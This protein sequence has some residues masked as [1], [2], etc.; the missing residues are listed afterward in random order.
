MWMFVIITIA[1][2]PIIYIYGNNEAG[3]MQVYLKDTGLKLTL[4]TYSLGNMGGATVICQQKKIRS[5]TNITLSC[6]NSQE[7]QMPIFD[8]RG[9]FQAEYGLIPD[10]ANTQT[11]CH[12]KNEDL[13]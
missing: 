12:S 1:C 3:G 10:N 4:A 6:P 13:I 2:I 7:A 11:Y 9:V 8:A 5:G